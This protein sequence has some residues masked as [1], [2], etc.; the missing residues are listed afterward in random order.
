MSTDQALESFER[1]RAKGKKKKEKAKGKATVKKKA[2]EIEKEIIA[3]LQQKY[4][5]IDPSSI[6][7]FTDL[8]LSRKTQQGL[9]AAGY[10]FPTDVQKNSVHPALLGRDIL[11]AAKTGS[12]KTLAFLLP[13]LESLWRLQWS[14]LDG[15]GALIITPTRELAYQIFEVLRKVGKKHDFSAGLV[16]GGKDVTQESEQIYRTNIVI[17]TP[18]RLLQ[19]MDETAY[20]EANNLQLLVLDEADRILDLGFAATMNAIIQ[21]LP[22]TRQTM[23]FSATQTKSVKDL[24]R[25]SLKNPVYISVHEHHKFSTPQKLKQ[26]YLVCELHQ[27]LDL[28]F[29]FIKNHLRSKILVFLSSC[30]QV[31]YVYEA[32]CR[33]QPG[34]SVLCLH[35]KMPQMKRV[36]VYNSFCRKQHVCLLAT[37]IAARGLDFPAVH[38]VLQLDCPEDADTYIHRAGRTARYESDGESLLVLMPSEER[39]M[40]QQLTD[41]KIP[42]EKIRVN[43][44]KFYSI[45]NKLEVLCAQDV[46]IKESAQ[47]CF[48]SY[49]RSYFLQPNK[50]VF[51]VNKL[52]LEN[53]ASSLGLAVAPRVRF[54]QNAAK[55]KEK[56][57]S[58][59]QTTSGMG[60]K[61]TWPQGEEDEEKTVDT[62]KQLVQS[63][64]V[65]QADAE[66]Y[67][68][69]DTT[70]KAGDSV[71]RTAGESSDSEVEQTKTKS[72]LERTVEVGTSQERE[73]SE[74]GESEDEDEKGQG[75]K[76]M[77]SWQQD[78]EEEDLLTVKKRDVFNVKGSIQEPKVLEIEKSSSNEKKTALTK[79]KLS[80]KLAKKKV[81]VNS[82][83]KFD[84]EGE[85]AEQWPPVQKVVLKG[86]VRE[87]GEEEEEE[88]EEVGGLNLETARK[89]MQEEDKHDKLAYKQRIRQKK[90]EKKMKLKEASRSKDQQRRK[91][92]TVQEEGVAYLDVGEEEEDGDSAEDAGSDSESDLG[93]GSDS[94][95][96]KEEDVERPRK[97]RKHT[98]S[99]SD[100]EEEEDDDLMDTGLDLHDDEELALHLL[101]SN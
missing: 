66:K 74:S 60:D 28:L 65:S 6:Q 35:G 91:T 49:L 4:K 41:K 58:K 93:Q 98:K 22:T 1:W 63:K 67:H 101:G 31:R 79:A 20:F 68:P 32:F 34:M 17:C 19:H 16:I 62:D 10:K 26:S 80:K 48:V 27:K 90:W 29:S 94:G 73:L 18:G 82:K 53:Y 88:E 3:K 95:S 51:D 43:P 40:L 83:V 59:E 55:G 57:A 100:E 64:T 23:L 2:W 87:E 11:G 46:H 7:K 25:L 72:L 76:G 37:D 12:G 70:S 75:T 8:P 77:L 89:L 30:K 85:V 61:H 24:A 52:P 54:L 78:D 56:T 45:Q 92:D 14:Q 15:L 36:D 50:Q 38:W 5:D 47:K 44:S 69:L 33:L 71:E 39:Q 96:D 42:V 81:K 84:D 9:Q 13:V 99:S 97:R 86:D 21:N